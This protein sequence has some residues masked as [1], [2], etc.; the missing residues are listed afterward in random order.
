LLLGL[1]FV[2]KLED[3]NYYYC[4]LDAIGG[5]YLDE[6]YLTYFAPRWLCLTPW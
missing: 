6:F 5:A 2:F 3:E 4:I 1:S